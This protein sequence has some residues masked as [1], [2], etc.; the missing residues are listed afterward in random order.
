MIY[1]SEHDWH[2]RLKSGKFETIPTLSRGQWGASMDDA[3][4]IYRNVN[5]APLFVDFVA[6]KYY[7]R[8]P[9][10]V[11]TRGLYDPL[12]SREASTIW[13]IRATRGVNRG[14][15]DQFFR[16]DDSS[17]TIQGVGTPVVY[18]GDRLPKELYG[19]AFITDSTTNLVHRY[20]IVDD[21]TGRLKA[22]DGYAKGEILV[23]WDERFRPVNMLGGPDGTLYVVDM[24]RG[25]VQ[26]AI[27]WTDFL[28]DYIKAR[29]LEQPVKLGRIWRIVHETTKPERKPALSKAT[30]A[31]LVQALSH[32]NGWWRDTAQRLLV[33]RGETSVAP[34]LKQLATQSPDWRTR[35]HA[36]W[37]LDGLDAIEP[38][39]VMPALK[40]KSADVRASAIRLA[41]RWPAELPRVLDLMKDPSWT[42][43]RQLAAT[44]GA[45][46][47][48]ERVAPAVAMLKAYGADPIVVD[49][50][51]GLRG[52]R[53]DPPK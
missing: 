5:D 2:L 50:V 4:R 18:R 9:N 11:R 53:P 32:P 17:V 24:Y 21:G 23:S 37:T 52:Q 3:G 10:L 35:L 39:Q 42:V 36:L 15:R 22:V 19:D 31:E 7:A 34:Q 1:T 44:I 45:L 28:R 49:C 51:S 27:Y 43:R 14:Y 40:D 29:D 41:E 38:A 20:K 25:I 6:A 26:E 16:P 13:P 8:N 12:I 47:P 48:A 33:E 30:P 46:A